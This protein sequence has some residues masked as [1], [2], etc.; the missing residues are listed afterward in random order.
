M[1]NKKLT[2][3][4]HQVLGLKKTIHDLLDQPVPYHIGYI[5]VKNLGV[6]EEIAVEIEVGRIEL[7]RRNSEPGKER[8]EETDPGWTTFQSE[9]REFMGMTVD[10]DLELIDEN[11]LPES[12][13]ITPRVINALWAML[14]HAPLTAAR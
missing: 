4:N 3:S 13:L 6:I 10:L 11:L 5:L 14:I 9:W 7:V 2:L 12:F 1:A 8:L